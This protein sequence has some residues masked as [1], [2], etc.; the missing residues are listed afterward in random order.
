MHIQHTYNTHT[1]L[2]MYIHEREIHVHGTLVL[3]S[4]KEKEGEVTHPTIAQTN[5]HV[6]APKAASDFARVICNVHVYVQYLEG[7]GELE[8]F[9]VA[10]C[11]V[12]VELG[13]VR[14]P[15]DSIVVVLY[16]LRELTCSHRGRG[17][18]GRGGEGTDG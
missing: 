11:P 14:V 15:L 4:Q 10:G 2:Y 9:L 1:C 16:S 3:R 13:V 5:K 17:G 7:Q 18:E 12:A 6:H 8:E